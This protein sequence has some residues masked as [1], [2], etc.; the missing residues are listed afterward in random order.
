MPTD[1]DNT[2]EQA[3]P[4]GAV[5]VVGFRIGNQTIPSFRWAKKKGL[6]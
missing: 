1:P 5:F 3:A 4:A 6:R 2:R